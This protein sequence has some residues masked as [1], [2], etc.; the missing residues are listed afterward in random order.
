MSNTPYD[1]VVIGGGINGT[2]IA[3]DAAGRGLRVLL[4]EAEDLAGATSSASSKLIHGGLRYLE[5]YAFRLVHE[6]LAERE[7]L[8]GKAPHIIW[9]LRFI[10]PQTPGMRPALML[11]AG[12]FL[13]DHLSS[14][15]TLGSS[16]A[17]NLSADPAGRPLVPDL[18]RGF[19]YWDCWVDDSRLV[20][21]NA[22]AARN[23]GAD[24]LTWTPVE[25][26]EIENAL[27]RISLGAGGHTRTIFARALVNAA[28][29][30]VE[31]IAK[32]ALGARNEPPPKVR[33]VKGS[34]I[35][36]PRIAGTNDAYIFQSDDGRVVF[37]LPFEGAFTLIGTTD[38][39]YTGN[40][41][42]VTV[43]SE[44]RSYLLAVAKRYF[45]IPLLDADI[46]WQFAGVRPLDDDGSDNPSAVS[47]DYRLELDTSG[48]VPILHVIGG[49]ITTYRRLA[50]SALALLQP[51]IDMGP[52]WTASAKL[53]GGDV[54]P[55]GYTTW[56]QDLAVRRSGFARDDL[57]R[58]S[59]RYGTRVDDLLDGA[60]GLPD[61]GPD[62]GG[63]L[64]R[65]EV[66]FLKREEWAWRADDVIWR[67]TKAALHVAPEARSAFAARVQTALDEA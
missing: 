43:T 40:P 6:A 61:L 48:G 25:A 62:L 15:R 34:H 56:F 8:L 7:V 31:T 49:K 44:D 4:A 26:I 36:V 3:A 41:R 57:E 13:Y 24:V 2:G 37:A 53:P 5:Q 60:R 33:L 16:R 18:R 59:R 20:V 28:G 67:R 46:V 45:S 19:S 11:R 17:L 23:K 29:P 30:W 42:D 55:G 47:R 66:E 64:S 32:L 12:L 51:H 54:G 35:V 9:P 1:L 22:I 38:S 14:R 63:K 21:L 39:T 50:E 52:P 65:R 58:L 27:W 10:L